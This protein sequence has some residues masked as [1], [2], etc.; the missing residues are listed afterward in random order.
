MNKK[1]KKVREKETLKDYIARHGN[2]K[3]IMQGGKRLSS[4]VVNGKAMTCRQRD[5]LVVFMYEKHYDI[6]WIARAFNMPVT[7]VENIISNRVR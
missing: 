1:S 4:V 3:G 6:N 5:N 2:E 7:S